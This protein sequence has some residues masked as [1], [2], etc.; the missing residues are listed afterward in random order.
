M[1]NGKT[2]YLN[3]GCGIAYLAAAALLI[4]DHA[5]IIDIDLGIVAP[6]VLVIIGAMI[7]ARGIVGSR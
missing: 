2:N 3:L 1:S 4:A 5:D 7:A 6:V